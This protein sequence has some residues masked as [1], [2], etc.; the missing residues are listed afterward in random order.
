VSEEIPVVGMREPCPCGS[1]KRYKACHGKAASR[2]ATRQ[3]RRPFQGM[4]SECDWVAFREIVPAAT[5]P[6]TLA[7]GEGRSVTLT[8]VL[9]LAWPALVRD[10]GE[11]FLALQ[12][13]TGSGDPSR[14]A[15]EALQRA[16]DAGDLAQLQ[17]ACLPALTPLRAALRVLLQSQAGG[18]SWRT[19]E[20]VQGLRRLLDSRP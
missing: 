14:D 3:V 16:L 13:T 10:T 11:I 4:A 2:A 9:P 7:S 12:T 19:R 18:A 5:A 17:A 6:L 8:T 1:G 20:V 15:A